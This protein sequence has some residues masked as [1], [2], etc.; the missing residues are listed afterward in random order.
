MKRIFARIICLL[1][2][3]LFAM[4]TAFAEQVPLSELK[5]QMPERLQMTITTKDGQTIEVDAPIVLPEVDKI[6]IVLVGYARFDLTDFYD[7]FPLPSY[8]DNSARESIEAYNFKNNTSI[9]LLAEE[10]QDRITGK[11]DS[12]VRASLSPGEIPPEN[13][14]TVEEIM[15]FIHENIERFHCDTKVD[16]RVRRATAKSGLFSMKKFKTPEGYR[17]YTIDDEKPVKNASRGIWHLELEQYIHGV[18]IFD[19]YLPY[20]D[21]PPNSNEWRMPFW[22]HA[23]YMDEKNFNIII[24]PVKESA[25]LIDD[26]PLLSYPELEMIVKEQIESGMLENICGLTLGYSVKIVKGDAFWTEAYVDVN[27]DTRFVLVPEWR[28]LGIDEEDAATA[29]SLGLEAIPKDTV[30][31]PESYTSR[32]LGY[33]RRIDAATGKFILDFE[34]LEYDL[35]NHGGE[36]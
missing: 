17:E 31:I 9:Q 16:I 25:I 11:V 33:E 1:C 30:L 22:F 8:Y 13:D 3:A 28:V 27:M 35:E 24:F 23:D 12:T 5:Q 20:G 21:I 6:P 4:Q 14:V 26:A 34:A 19:E 29:E 36:F 18:P 7:E 2:L 10:K 32:Y 15:A